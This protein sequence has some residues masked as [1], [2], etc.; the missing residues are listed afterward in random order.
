MKLCHWQLLRGDFQARLFTL[1]EE[2]EKLKSRR[3]ALCPL[4]LLP[5]KEYLL[6]SLKQVTELKLRT[7]LALKHQEP[8]HWLCR[9]QQVRFQG[10]LF[11][12]LYCF[13]PMQIIIK[14]IMFKIHLGLQMRTTR[15]EELSSVQNQPNL[16]RVLKW[17]SLWL[18]FMRLA[19]SQEDFWRH[20]HCAKIAPNC[21]FKGFRGI[22]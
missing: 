1:V 7:Q 14:Q 6:W 12:G 11:R 10:K 9:P 17:K 18:S 3:L 8:H 19:V 5:L 13:S 16:R 4:D 15:R 21:S 22:L 20:D 2:E